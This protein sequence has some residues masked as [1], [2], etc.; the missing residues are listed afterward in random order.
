[1][2]VF[3]ADEKKN[4]ETLK[5][6]EKEMRKKINNE[7]DYFLEN[8]KDKG[9]YWRLLEKQNNLWESFKK[10]EIN[11]FDFDSRQKELYYMLENYNNI[12][13]IIKLKKEILDRIEKIKKDLVKD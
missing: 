3:L 1:M 12:F 13:Y 6:L 10:Y 7:F 5:D 8:H 2:E 9:D 11:K 4:I